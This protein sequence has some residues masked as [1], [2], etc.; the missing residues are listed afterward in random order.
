MEIGVSGLVSMRSESSVVATLPDTVAGDAALDVAA[1]L[2]AG[3]AVVDAPSL[4]ERSS[5]EPAEADSCSSGFSCMSRLLYDRINGEASK[6]GLNAHASAEDGKAGESCTPQC[7]GLSTLVGIL[8]GGGP[9]SANFDR[10]LLVVAFYQ[11]RKLTT[12]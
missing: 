2:G 8:P 9:T 3:L 11:E 12:R 7:S 1:A 6:S 5:G 4:G 10:E